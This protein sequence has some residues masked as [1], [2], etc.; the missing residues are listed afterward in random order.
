MSIFSRLR[1]FENSRKAG[2]GA[3]LAG[4]AGALAWAQLAGGGIVAT[5]GGNGGSSLHPVTGVELRAT[6]SQPKIVQGEDGTVYLDL[7]VITPDLLERGARRKPSDMIVVLDRSGSMGE[8]DKWT[9]AT[10][11]VHS[12]LDRLSSDDRISLIT[13]DTQARVDSRLVLATPENIAQLHTLVNRLGPGDSTNLGDGLEAAAR[14]LIETSRGQRLSRVL[15]LSDGQANVGVVEPEALGAMAKRLADRGA[16]VSTIGMGLGFNETLMA[17]LADL[18]MG[19]FSYLEHLDL[20]ANILAKELN[21]SRSIFAEGSEIRVQLPSGVE[22]VEAS[23]Y[24]FTVEGSTAVIRTGQLLQGSRKQFM[25]ALRVSNQMV[26]DYP[27]GVELK[28]RSGN[29][30]FQQRI[31]PSFL[32]VACVSPEKRKEAIASI[33]RDVYRDAWIQNNLGSMMRQVGD[34]VRNGEREKAAQT[35]DDF[36]SKLDEADAVVPGL[37]K[38]GGR[39]LKDLEDRVNLAFSGPDQATKQN[40]AAK[41]MLNDSQTRQRKTQKK[42]Q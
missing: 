21:D 28:Y 31:A 30:S 24:P 38:E 35:I 29:R 10:Q 37:K 19:S 20:L 32:R 11:A 26:A 4:V 39:E 13:F 6:L 36:K 25:S 15:L 40:R 18:G 8:A 41:S 22:L 1:S 27:I 2:I 17:S 14:T 34:Y 7:S 23:G 9:Y 5:A 3:L 12:L 16:V 33:D 42:G